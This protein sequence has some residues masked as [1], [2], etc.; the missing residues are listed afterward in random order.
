M[1]SQQLG[2]CTN[3]HACGVAANRV[4]DV[5]VAQLGQEGFAQ[6]TKVLDNLCPGRGRHV[7][8]NATG[9]QIEQLPKT[10]A[11]S[12]T[13]T[14]DA[15]PTPTTATAERDRHRAGRHAANHPH[16]LFV[17]SPLTDALGRDRIV[18]GAPYELPSDGRATAEVTEH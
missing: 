18:A 4:E 12:S 2:C 16:T 10:G 17:R 15:A 3:N 9:V 14:L 11:R 5:P 6:L 1:A 8:V 7:A 13:F